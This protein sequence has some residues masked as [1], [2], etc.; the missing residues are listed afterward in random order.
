MP[1]FWQNS[2]DGDTSIKFCIKYLQIVL[3]LKTTLAIQISAIF[4]MAAVFQNGCLDFKHIVLSKRANYSSFGYKSMK[5]V[6][7]SL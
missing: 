5:L 4:K 1:L 6:I 3:N 7:N 2:S